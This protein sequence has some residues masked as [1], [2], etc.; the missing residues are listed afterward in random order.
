[1]LQ[2]LTFAIIAKQSKKPDSSFFDKFAGLFQ[3]FIDV[4]KPV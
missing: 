1:M 2:Q 4:H 3:F